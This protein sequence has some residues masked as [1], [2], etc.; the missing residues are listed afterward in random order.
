MTP[1]AHDGRYSNILAGD[2]R[3][4][5]SLSSAAPPSIIGSTVC[6]GPSMA[7][8]ASL[9][10]LLLWCCRSLPSGLARPTVV[11]IQSFRLQ[12]EAS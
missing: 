6:M 8:S 12:S 7:I 3:G 11:A 9:A 2:H 4:A 1:R 5:D 10:E